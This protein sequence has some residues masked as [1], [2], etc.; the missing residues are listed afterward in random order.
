[1]SGI[2]KELLIEWHRPSEKQNI[3]LRCSQGGMTLPEFVEQLREELAPR[4]IKVALTEKTLPDSAPE[5][6]NS[7]YLNG[8]LMEDI[9]AEKGMVGGRCDSCS[10]SA[11]A[12][13]YCRGMEYE[14]GLMVEEIPCEAIKRAALLSI[15]AEEQ[16]Q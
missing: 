14:G 5:Q 13:P 7:I 16:K 8:R 9:L 6:I 10:C 4:D 3:L 1:M 12:D 11:G 15:E 2:M